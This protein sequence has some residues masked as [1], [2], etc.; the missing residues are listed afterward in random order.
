VSAWKQLE[1][2]AAALFGGTRK[3]ANSGERLDFETDRTVGQVKLRRTLS[4]EALT[5][6]AEEME[7]EGD[8]ANKLGVVAVKVRRGKG[9]A[10]PMLICV[11]EKHWREIVW[12]AFQG[13]QGRGR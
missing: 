11:T 3:W 9:K 2:D 13:W 12:R 6:L 10:S 4:L 1:R 8:K 7:R 5:Q